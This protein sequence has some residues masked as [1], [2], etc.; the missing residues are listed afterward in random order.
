MD[1]AHWQFHAQALE[2]NY[3]GWIFRMSQTYSCHSSAYLIFDN[4]VLLYNVTSCHPSC[5]HSQYLHCS[6]IVRGLEGERW[7][8][9]RETLMSVPFH[10]G[11]LPEWR[12]ERGRRLGSRKSIY[13][14]IYVLRRDLGR[15]DARRGL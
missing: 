15:G 2:Y 4:A 10:R 5:P 9:R 7:W 14:F 13:L 12:R 8:K 3:H 6:G 11:T 1:I